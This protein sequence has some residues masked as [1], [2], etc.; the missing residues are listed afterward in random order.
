MS[1]DRKL[2]LGKRYGGMIVKS[3]RS[4]KKD[5]RYYIRCICNVCSKEVMRERSN[6]RNGRMNSCG[7]SP[8][9]GK[10]QRKAPVGVYGYGSLAMY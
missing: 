8:K 9:R 4:Y 10:Y 3:L 6:V 7:C 2:E 5:G 1:N